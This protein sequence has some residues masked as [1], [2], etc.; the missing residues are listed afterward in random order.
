[1][2]LCSIFIT[3]VNFTCVP[4]KVD[5]LPRA[6]QRAHRL[7]RARSPPWSKARW[8]PRESLDK[9][10]SRSKSAHKS[11]LRS[12]KD[13]LESLLYLPRSVATKIVD[14]KYRVTGLGLP[15]GAAGHRVT[16]DGSVARL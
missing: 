8:K 4:P 9:A 2:D 16:E 5:G 12:F 7:P 10:P 6:V 11:T 14:V 15:A 1:M 3:F 13:S